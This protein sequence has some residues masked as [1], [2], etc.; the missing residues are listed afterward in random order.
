MNMSH[1]ID[2]RQ[3]KLV[4]VKRYTKDFLTTI[5]VLMEPIYMVQWNKKKS[6]GRFFLLHDISCDFNDG[7][8]SIK[9]LSCLS[10]SC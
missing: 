8:D 2:Q 7:I 4:E 9:V 1:K 5:D 10:N 3:E 6:K